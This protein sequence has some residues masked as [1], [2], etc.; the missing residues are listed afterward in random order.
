[1]DDEESSVHIVKLTPRL[2]AISTKN[3][4]ILYPFLIVLVLATSVEKKNR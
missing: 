2:D 3:F 1:M 4:K